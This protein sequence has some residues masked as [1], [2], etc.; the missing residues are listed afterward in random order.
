MNT[1]RMPGFTAEASIYRSCARYGGDPTSELGRSEE[2][3]IQPAL[4]MQTFCERFGSVRM[5]CWVWDGGDF[6]MKSTV[7]W[8]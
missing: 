2:G 8:P 5:C 7:F 3:M 6:V 1:T 4:W